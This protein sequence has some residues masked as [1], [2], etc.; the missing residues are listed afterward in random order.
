M[1]ST[2]TRSQPTEHLQ[3]ILERC[4]STLQ[5]H[6]Q[7][8]K[9]GNIFWKNAVHPLTSDFLF[10]VSLILSLFR[11]RLSH[12]ATW[13]LMTETRSCLL[14][15]ST[16]PSFLLFPQSVLPDNKPHYTHYAEC[17]PTQSQGHGLMF[18][19]FLF[20]QFVYFLLSS[21]THLSTFRYSHGPARLDDGAP[22]LV[23]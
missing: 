13:T 8:V 12:F 7:D 11:Q 4:V 14:F 3:N 18:L 23:A 16:E 5:H 6:H 22:G 10:H 1:A 15:F 9:W 17:R 19:F 20:A 2:V 21:L